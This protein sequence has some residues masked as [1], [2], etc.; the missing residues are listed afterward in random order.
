MKIIKP[1]RGKS[2]YTASVSIYLESSRPNSIFINKLACDLM[3]FE[4]EGFLL[5]GQDEENEEIFYI[6]KTKKHMGF[7]YKIR[8]DRGAIMSSIEFSRLIAN[9]FK[10]NDGK[11]RLSVSPKPIIKDGL[12]CYVLI[13][14]DDIQ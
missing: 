1:I 10:S 13:N 6:I 8:G 11:V 9:T 12:E 14:E 7:K 5:F 4:D 2:V 3:R